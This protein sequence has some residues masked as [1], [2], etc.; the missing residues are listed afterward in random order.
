MPKDNPHASVNRTSVRISSSASPGRAW[1]GTC[2]RNAE[3]RAKLPHA[4]RG[5]RPQE[6]EVNGPY[7]GSDWRNQPLVAC[8]GP[9]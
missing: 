1:P 8:V 3:S 7:G 4:S 5:G 9:W 6:A 2:G